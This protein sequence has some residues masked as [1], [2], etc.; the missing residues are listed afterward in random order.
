VVQPEVDLVLQVARRQACDELEPVHLHEEP[1]P[2]PPL[3]SIDVVLPAAM[4]AEPSE[5]D[6]CAT[7]TFDCR[8][9]SPKLHPMDTLRGRF[10]FLLQTSLCKELS[11]V[12]EQQPAELLKAGCEC[13]AG[14]MKGVASSPSDG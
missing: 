8:P 2:V 12:I 13:F 4:D 7:K 6:R 11:V 5:F 10:C 14:R 1:R 9:A 3:V